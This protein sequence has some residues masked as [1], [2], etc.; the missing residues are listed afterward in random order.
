MD[1]AAKLHAYLKRRMPLA[2]NLKVASLSRIIY[3]ASRDTFAF[4]ICWEENGAEREQGLVL[5]RDPP[6]GLLDHISRQTEFRI[7]K[8]LEGSGIPVPKAF[9]CETDPDILERSFIIMERVEG[10]VTRAFQVVGGSNQSYRRRIA[11]DFVSILARIHNLDW[12]DRG[13]QFLGEPQ[14]SHDYATQTIAEWGAILQEVMFEPDLVLTEALIWLKHNIP[15]NGEI[16]LVHGD[17]KSDNIMCNGEEIVAVFDWEMASLGDPHD[18]LGWVCMQYY[19]V[20][21]LINGLMKRDWFLQRYEELSGRRVNPAAVKFWQVLCNVKMAAITLTG[22]HR[23]L[24]GGSTKNV[25]A[26]LPL[27]M[28]KLHRDIIELLAF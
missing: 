25:M 12:R 2:G 11:E 8:S 13:L 14:D 26:V 18:D 7:L 19:S 10:L 15:P 6:T 4:D 5:R 1:T 9:W 28:P 16:C 20:D 21:G 27:L 22:L 17:Y 23:Y 24:T 3:G